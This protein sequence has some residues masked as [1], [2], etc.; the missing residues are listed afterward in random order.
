MQQNDAIPHPAGDAFGPASEIA[1]AATPDRAAPV[2]GRERIAHLDVLRGV[3]LW[4]IF[5]VNLPLFALPIGIWGG[6]PDPASRTAGETF[7]YALVRTGFEFKFVTLFSILFGAGFAMQ[8]VRG[9][10]RGRTGRYLRRIVVLAAFGAAHA[11]ALWYGDI[12]L[13]YAIVGTVLLFFRR[14]RPA[15]CLRLGIAAFAI[16]IVL[17][18]LLTALQPAWAGTMADLRAA[19]APPV[20]HRGWRF[21]A[22]AGRPPMPE[23]SVTPAPDEPVSET[24]PEPPAPPAAADAP[25]TFLAPTD[26]GWIA[27]E[28]AAYREGPYL[29]AFVF[30]ASSYLFFMLAYGIP[31]FGWR[32]L[33]AFLIG[34][35][36]IRSGLFANDPAAAARRRRLALAGLGI[37]LPLELLSTWRALADAGGPPVAA[38]IAAFLHEAGSVALALGY[39][40]AVSVLVDRALALRGR[41]GPVLDAFARLGRVALSGYLLETLLATAIFYHWGA[42]RFATL[43]RAELLP[44][45]IAV[46]MVVTV[47]AGLWTRRF[48]IGPF[49]WLWRSATYLRPM[50]LGRAPVAPERRG[51]PPPD[52]RAT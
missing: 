14:A 17:A 16:G 35:W 40:G 23:V 28:T 7:A 36:A 45:A 30:R 51:D 11:F 37:G 15:T 18:T 9:D 48:A 26:P 13:M 42:A 41:L 49:E 29:D 2:R 33:G 5:A 10:E 20:E 12:L 1:A 44:I 47:L 27:A 4:G 43:D 34:V 50:P 46:P 24:G 8:M 39:L 25:P 22:E 38:A 32:V 31:V 3:A 19:T 21:F 6:V 52:P